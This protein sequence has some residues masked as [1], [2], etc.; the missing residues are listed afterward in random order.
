MI[1]TGGENVYP[2][3]VEESLYMRP[4]IEECAVVGFPD[5]EW[6]EKV[7][8][9][10]VPRPGQTVVPD[11][12]KSFLKTRLSPFKVPKEYI[13][14]KDLPKSPAGKILKRELRKIYSK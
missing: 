14:V 7:T 2:K 5:K 13:V 8:V 10:I 1:I 12:V 9:F 6:G 4:E 3:E 11:E